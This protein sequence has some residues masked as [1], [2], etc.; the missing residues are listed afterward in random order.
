M[1]IKIHRGTHQI[2]GCVT[3]YEYDGWHLFVDY[4]EELPGGPKTGDLQV[5]GLTKGDL[6]KSALLI[7]HYHGD[8]IGSVPKLPKELPIYMGDL[9]LKIQTVLSEHLKTVRPEHEAM[10]E[11]L[12]SVKTFKEGRQ[13]K[14]GPFTIMPVTVDHSAFDAYAFK[15]STNEASVYHTGDFRMH[16]F[17]SKK[18]D[19]MLRVFVGKV[20]YVVCEA[21]NVFRPEATSKTE[22]EL[23]REFYNLFKT[24]HGCIV[25]LSSTNID[26]LFSLYHAALDARR[27]FYVDNYQKRIMDAIVNSDSIWT[28]SGLYQYGKY[29]PRP[30][31]YDDKNKDAFFIS[32]K[33]I[34]FLNQKG[35]VLIA[36][37]NSR[38]DNLIEQIPGEKVKILSMWKEYVNESSPAY[39]KDLAKSLG[40]VFEH[41]HTSGHIDMKDMREFLSILN[42]KGVIPIHTDN[43]EQF[44]KEFGNEKNYLGGGLHSPK[45]RKS[46]G[47]GGLLQQL[48]EIVKSDEDLVIEIRN[49]YF[50]IYYKGGNIAKVVSEN[51]IQFDH[52][53]FKGYQRPKYESEKKETER[54]ELKNKWLSILKKQ[55]NYNDFVSKMKDLMNDYWT[56]LKEEKGKSLKEKDVQH[57]LCVYNT[58]LSEYTIIDVEFQV[59]TEA[60][61]AYKRPIQPK[62]RFVASKKTSP[63]FDIVAVRNSDHQLCVIELKSGVNALYGKSGIGDHADSFEG[64]IGRMPKVFLNEIKGV[65]NDKKDYGLLSNS[66][67][68]S[69]NNPEFV[70]AY[71]FKS[72][73]KD[74]DGNIVNKER[75]KALF[76]EE[77]NSMHCKQYRV[78]FLEE[79]NYT[80]SDNEN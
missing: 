53:Y 61:Y 3:E 57:S 19:K 1:N 17:R 12:K 66:F 39:N 78:M 68:I 29:K 36:R 49:N 21:T 52:N 44:A 51:S 77:M 72:D 10:L 25:Y 70:Y 16:G 31:K 23:Q 63:R 45:L 56:W 6:S 41:E 7:T 5:E 33:F 22:S 27:P 48:L 47:E 73:E 75:Q 80:L 4:G 11:R 34:D 46:L 69:D 13:F 59:S 15:I 76:I 40:N 43:P 74:R 67:E 32:D 30:L 8:H 24:N 60:L 14:F 79:N 71:S 50:N 38:F 2:G 58:E 55:R 28:K 62:G 65:V 42:P 54:K 35:Y 9:G 18:M 37:A 20:D 26:R 64:T